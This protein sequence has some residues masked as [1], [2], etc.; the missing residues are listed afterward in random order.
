MIEIRE[1]NWKDEEGIRG[2]FLNCFGK[3][4]SH[5]EW[6]WKYKNSPWGSTAAIALDGDRVIAHYGG[7]K[8]K[9]YFQGLE[10][11]VFQPCDVMT[12]PSY[13]ARLFTKKGAMVKAAELFYNNAMDF[14]FGFPSERHAIL[15]TK[16][17]GYTGHGY[18]NEMT[19]DI[20]RKDYRLKYFWKMN[21]GWDSI[22]ALEI[23]RLWDEN[24]I[25]SGLSIQKDSNYINWRYTENPVKKYLPVTLRA[26]L[27][28]KVKVFLIAFL[29]EEK[30]FILDYFCDKNFE[31]EN[32][33]MIFNKL[34]I[35]YGLSK[36]NLW[37][38]PADPFYKILVNEG[39]IN[40][41][42]IPYI[43]KIINPKITDTFLF[44]NYF[45]RMGDY[46]AS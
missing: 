25:L 14:A 35:D 29:N 26:L 20:V 12:H 3:E 27:N 36:V 1:F 43:F 9:F 28:K 23:N 45:Y 8:M 42:S 15:G 46:D 32:L 40:L 6:V 17:L 41:K 5:E 34:A 24:K 38:H 7:I 16:I 13:R 22:D 44:N 19:K 39:F 10:F 18:I 30:L 4:M 11:N 31:K 37:V 33:I 2:L 21:I